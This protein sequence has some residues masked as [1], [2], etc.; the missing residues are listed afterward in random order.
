MSCKCSRMSF[1]ICPLES[2][3]ACFRHQADDFVSLSLFPPKVEK[4]LLSSKSGTLILTSGTCLPPTECDVCLGAGGSFTKCPPFTT[5]HPLALRICRRV[6]GW[7]NV[8]V[9]SC[10]KKEARKL[11]RH[12]SNLGSFG[13]TVQ[14]W[15]WHRLVWLVELWPI[16]VHMVCNGNSDSNVWFPKVRYALKDFGKS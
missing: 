2:A 10:V 9:M 7:T 4:S 14:M 16:L 11:W 5:K 13:V 1:L 8:T 3:A 12:S 15:T 6:W